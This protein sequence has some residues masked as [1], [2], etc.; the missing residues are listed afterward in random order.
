[1]HHEREIPGW[2]QFEVGKYWGAGWGGME[3]RR[4]VG[5]LL[6]PKQSKIKYAVSTLE[7][8]YSPGKQGHTVIEFHMRMQAGE[9]GQKMQTWLPYDT[10]VMCV[11]CSVELHKPILGKATA[12]QRAKTYHQAATSTPSKV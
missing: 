8:A 12:R 2:S 6:L 5:G 7:A 10:V 3:P 4:E 1:M 9:V 11:F